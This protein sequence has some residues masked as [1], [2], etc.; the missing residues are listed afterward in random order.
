MFK[1]AVDL[2]KCITQTL[3]ISLYTCAPKLEL[4][5]IISTMT[6]VKKQFLGS[7]SG[8]SYGPMEYII[9]ILVKQSYLV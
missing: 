3:P 7:E 6:Q 1:F 8:S 5:S 2:N 4:P 9:L